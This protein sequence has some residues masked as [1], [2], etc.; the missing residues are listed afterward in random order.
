[1]KISNAAVY[2]VRLATSSDWPTYKGIIFIGRQFLLQVK[3]YRQQS[4]LSYR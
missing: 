2:K 4:S 1:M 3:N